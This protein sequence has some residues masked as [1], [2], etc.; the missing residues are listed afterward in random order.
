MAKIQEEQK[1]NSEQ[2]GKLDAVA[3]RNSVSSNEDVD[4]ENL[5]S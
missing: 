4:L 2:A 1:K 3:D 5:Q